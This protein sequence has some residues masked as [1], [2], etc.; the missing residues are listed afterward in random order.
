MM[1]GAWTLITDWNTEVSRGFPIQPLCSVRSSFVTE[2]VQG[3]IKIDT[4][5]AAMGHPRRFPRVTRP[6]S[7]AG[8]GPDT[9]FSLMP[10][11]NPASGGCAAQLRVSRP[12]TC[13]RCLSMAGPPWHHRAV[14][15]TP[16]IG[17]R[18]RSTAAI[19]PRRPPSRHFEADTATTLVPVGHSKHYVDYGGREH[20]DPVHRLFG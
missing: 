18:R 12:A 4:C 17:P 9:S 19:R 13:I 16:R 5:P 14:L 1:L 8:C 20:G 15:T 11:N 6:R 7:H 3:R 2:R 10:Q